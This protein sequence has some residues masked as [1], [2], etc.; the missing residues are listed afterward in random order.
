MYLKALNTVN[1]L[2]IWGIFTLKKCF[3]TSTFQKMCA[4]MHSG[5]SFSVNV[6]RFGLLTF[7]P[8]LCRELAWFALGKLLLDITPSQSIIICFY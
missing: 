5:N 4:S 1:S 3:L 7:Y 8:I 6:S 2:R